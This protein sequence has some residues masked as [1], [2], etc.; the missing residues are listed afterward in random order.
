MSCLIVIP[1]RKREEQ[2]QK[3]L[4]DVIPL[5]VK[6]LNQFKVVVME[7]GDE[8][9]FNRGA[10]M[11]IAF[12]EYKNKYDSIITNDVDI[13]PTEDTVK[14]Y[15]NLQQDVVR[16]FCAHKES[17]GGICKI[18]SKIF[19]MC[20][21]FPSDIWGWG[22]EDR[23]LYFRLK[24]F[25]VVVNSVIY[26]PVKLLENPENE[27]NKQIK[28]NFIN[29]RRRQIENQMFR[30]AN[31]EKRKNYYFKSGLNTL[32]YTIVERKQ[33]HKHVDLIKIIF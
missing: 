15:Y 3:F 27:N 23:S 33:I 32:Q 14:K 12:K 1:F 31:L 20:N 5:F 11:N 13:F 4:K 26:P 8:K 29:H 2:L 10:L 22:V 24:T 7:Q 16:I 18:N 30:R 9:P 21:G 19:S 6:H 25:N 28:K 17:C